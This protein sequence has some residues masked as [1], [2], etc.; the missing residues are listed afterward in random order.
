MPRV[1]AEI[2]KIYKL[3]TNI[4]DINVRE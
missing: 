2:E 4:G 3:I 1:F